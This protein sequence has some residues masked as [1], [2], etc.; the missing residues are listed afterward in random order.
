MTDNLP[1]KRATEMSVSPRDRSR[2]ATLS[3][4]LLALLVLFTASCDR[5]SADARRSSPRNPVAVNPMIDSDDDGFPD[6]AELRTAS[7]RENFRRWFTAIA[8]SQFYQISQFWVLEQQ[9][10]AGL[11]RFSMREALRP[12]D[13]PWMKA[14][15]EF[16]APVAPDPRKTSLGNSLLGEKLFRTT[17]GTFKEPDLND[18]TFSEFADARTLRNFNVN[19]VSRDRRDARPGDLLFFHQPWVQNYPFHVMIFLG[20]AREASEGAGDWVVYHTGTTPSANSQT[21]AGTIKKV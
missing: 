11:V 8:E 1:M 14:F 5:L 4:L 13:R 10:C 21:D 9:D 16:E 20:E 17:Y 6:V 18:G 19:A 3:L 2:I 7:E 12:H 15:P